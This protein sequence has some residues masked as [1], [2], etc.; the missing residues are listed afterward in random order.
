MNHNGKI[1]YMHR[2]YLLILSYLTSKIN[3]FLNKFVNN[4]T[5]KK[6]LNVRYS[7]NIRSIN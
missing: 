4:F 3:D 5:Y 2:A 1:N 6:R 7:G